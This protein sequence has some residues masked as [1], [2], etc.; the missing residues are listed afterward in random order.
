MQQQK[1]WVIGEEDWSRPS[2]PAATRDEAPAGETVDAAA[3]Q[4]ALKNPALAF[5]LSLLVWGSGQFYLREQRRGA[6]FLAGLLLRLTL[7]AALLLWHEP[8]ARVF[9]VSRYQATL[10]SFGA[11][12]LLLSLF[13]GPISALD[14]Y[15]LARPATAEPFAGVD[16]VRW[17]LLGS[18]VCP[19]WGQVLNGQLRKGGFF[20]VSG[21]A[22]L[23]AALVLL[24]APRLFPLLT[25][26]GARLVLEWL[27]CGALVLAP[28]AV[29]AWV[30]A[31]FDAYRCCRHL[32]RKN[33]TLGRVGFRAWAKELLGELHSRAT[34]I[35]GLLLAISV[36]MQLLP[37]KYY[38]DLLGQIRLE[39]THQHLVLLPELA[40]TVMG[41]L[42]K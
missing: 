1:V 5:S 38:L 18:L 22:G 20:L 29:V 31:M 41:L 28:L 17:P 12:T 19:G 13:I 4:A 25:D 36:G 35:L 34:L 2:R 24:G 11:M 14:A 27:L 40:R 7:L 37:R 6:F 23:F 33:F 21:A 16:K 39:M 10:L 26:P 30:L 8:L 3:A 15:Q 32:Y 9:A 42:G